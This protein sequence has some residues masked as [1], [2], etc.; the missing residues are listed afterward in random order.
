MTGCQIK[1]AVA[2]SISTFLYILFDL[3][4]AVG[5]LSRY[6]YITY[7]TELFH[8]AAEKILPMLIENTFQALK[9]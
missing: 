8:Y 6:V 4:I 7:N 3:K 2:L 1:S 5:S 9:I